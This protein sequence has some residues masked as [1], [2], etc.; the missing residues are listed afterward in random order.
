MYRRLG[1]TWGSRKRSTGRMP[2]Y[3][4]ARIN[5]MLR[6][7][8]TYGFPKDGDKLIE[9]GTGWLHWE[10]ITTRLFFDVRCTLFDV[11]D[12]RQIDG[13]KNYLGQLDCLIDQLDAS[14]AQRT[15]AR[16]LISKIN[17]VHDY[18]ELYALLSF[19]YVLD[20]SGDLA[21]F[22]PGSF[23]IAVSAGVLE[24][25]YA[26]DT[27]AY[28]DGIAALL[29]PGGYSIHSINIRDHL[30]AYD[31]SVSR[32]QYLRY[33]PWIWRL[34]FENDVQYINRIQRPE[35]RGLFEKAGLALVEEEVELEDLSG[36]K[37]AASYSQYDQ[38]DLSCGGLKLVHR[39]SSRE[40]G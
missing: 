24:H 8:R 3:Y 28:V 10:A 5:R 25:V 21:K 19:E 29:K 32:K 20:P 40:K 12:N 23:D 38:T 27:A 11:W 16:Q 31:R 35:W 26:E 17:A 6:I 33:P 18:A 22:P 36:L 1:N 15:R 14:Q 4:P 7:A 9:L 13:L 30:Y 2:S 37:I 39:K 34:F